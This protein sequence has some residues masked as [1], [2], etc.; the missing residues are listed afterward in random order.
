MR[1][2][3]KRIYDAP[4]KSD[5]YRVLVDRIWPR[6]L[7]KDA[8]QV[9]EWLKDV[10]PS[11]PLRRWFGHEPDKWS[12]F[13]RLYLRE[14]AANPEAAARLQA[15]ARRRRVTLLFGAKDTLRNNAVVLSEYL[16]KTH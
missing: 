14:L 7:S 11:T 6:G 12:E 10:A 15:L 9:D 5:G 3:I 13:R 4:E 1:V 8:A 2:R 16:G